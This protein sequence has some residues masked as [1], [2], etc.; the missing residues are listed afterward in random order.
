MEFNVFILRT[1]TEISEIYFIAVFLI[2]YN[3]V[4]IVYKQHNDYGVLK[5]A[6]M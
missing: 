4:M 5:L 6:T 2:I 3:F 1:M